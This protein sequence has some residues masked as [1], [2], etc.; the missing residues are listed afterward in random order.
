MHE[1]L[2][3]AAEIHYHV[4]K[5]MTHLTDYGIDD[6]PPWTPRNRPLMHIYQAHGILLGSSDPDKDVP[7]IGFCTCLFV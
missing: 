5:F 4:L 7:G 6:T 1:T 2:H 3:A